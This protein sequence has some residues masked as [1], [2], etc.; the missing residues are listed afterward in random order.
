M[1]QGSVVSGISEGWNICCWSAITFFRYIWSSPF[2]QYV[3]AH[4][5]YHQYLEMNTRFDVVSVW[6]VRWAAAQC[7]WLAPRLD[8]PCSSLH[9][10]A[11][12]A[13]DAS[14]EHLRWAQG[15]C[16]VVCC[17]TDC[18][19]LV[20]RFYVWELAAQQQQHSSRIGWSCSFCCRTNEGISSAKLRF[21]TYLLTYLPPV[22]YTSFVYSPRSCRPATVDL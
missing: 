2:V 5:R 13:S 14:I 22:T 9:Y 20:G 18:C 8:S 11:A 1:L 6:F 15:C 4:V 12:A 10:S 21:V 17:L 3:S 19:W 7:Y 16:G